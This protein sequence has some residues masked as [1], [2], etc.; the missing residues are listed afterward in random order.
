[1]GVV[2]NVGFSK[3]PKQGKF[4]KRRVEVC[5][6]YDPSN[7]IEGEIVR[8][9]SEEPGVLIIKLDDGRYVLATECM[10]A[11]ITKKEQ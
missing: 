3:F 9:D 10:Y 11:F 2:K 4:L 1:M 6:N 7:R 5:F 8:D